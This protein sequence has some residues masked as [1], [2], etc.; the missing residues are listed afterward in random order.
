M[1]R[2]AWLAL[3]NH[4][5]YNIDSDASRQSIDHDTENGPFDIINISTCAR[6]LS[7]LH[8]YPHCVAR[9]GFQFAE[10]CN[11]M[12]SVQLD[13]ALVPFMYKLHVQTTIKNLLTNYIQPAW[14]VS[15]V[16]MGWVT[17]SCV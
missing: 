14:F 3:L 13:G 4:V 10:P 6:S 17:A 12:Q 5:V 1:P 8:P 9:K 16:T 11:L 7:R 15:A 2:S